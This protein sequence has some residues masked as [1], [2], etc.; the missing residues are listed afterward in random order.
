MYYFSHISFLFHSTLIGFWLSQQFF[1]RATLARLTCPLD[2][3]DWVVIFVLS[4]RNNRTLTL[5][6][7]ACDIFFSFF[8][9]LLIKDRSWAS[10]G[11]NVLYSKEVQSWLVWPVDWAPACGPEGHRLD[12]QS[13][14]MRG[15]WA[16][17]LVGGMR[18]A[19]APC[20][21]HTS[22]FSP[23]LS[24]SFPLSLKRSK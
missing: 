16:R 17:S 3:S 5:K 24:P 11:K 18:E 22:C 7:T 10:L 12:S 1:S 4:Y 8:L 2:H 21:S 23:S 19:T 13:E 6:Q 14:H 20:F 9:H 15:F